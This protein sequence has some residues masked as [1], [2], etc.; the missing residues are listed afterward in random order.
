MRTVRLSVTFNDQ[1]N[2]LLD[3][4]E[5]R[6]GIAVVEQKKNL[7]YSTIERI[8]VRHPNAKRRDPGHGLCA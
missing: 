6:F 7:V 1:L 5:Q 4:G 2:V 8:I 3:Q